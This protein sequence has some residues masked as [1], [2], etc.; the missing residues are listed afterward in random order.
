[1]YFFLHVA[2]ITTI[3]ILLYSGTLLECQC[4]YVMLLLLLTAYYWRNTYKYSHEYLN[5]VFTLLIQQQLLSNLT[6]S[7]AKLSTDPKGNA[8]T[9]I[10]TIC[11]MQCTSSTKM[12]RERRSD[13]SYWGRSHCYKTN[14][15]RS[16]N[17]K[18][19]LF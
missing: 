4:V 18:G 12:K 1:M 14:Q 3:N 10:T 8:Q 5:Q 19:P 7:Y 15:Y 2:P 17:K 13:L 16:A 9:G 6:T 11:N